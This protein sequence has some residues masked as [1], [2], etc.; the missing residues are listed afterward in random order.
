MDER[1]PWLARA[2]LPYLLAGVAWVTIGAVVLGNSRGL[3]L[4]FI[5]ITCLA[6]GS[7]GAG[8]QLLHRRDRGYVN[9]SR[10]G[11]RL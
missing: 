4:I 3:G 8:W 7:Y 1:A 6:F 9:R 11:Q 10:R 2:W 5:G